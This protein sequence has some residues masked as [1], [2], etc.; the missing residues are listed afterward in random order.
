MARTITQIQDEIISTRET[1]LPTLNS[2]SRVAVWRLWTYVIAV[3]I[4]AVEKL[5]D[6]HKAEVNDIIARQKPHSLAWYREKAKAFQY[7]NDLPDGSDTY[8]IIREEDRIVKYAAAIERT[9]TVRL[10]VAKIGEPAEPGGEEDL[11][12]LSGAEMDNFEPYMHRVKDAGV[13]LIIN[14][15]TADL[16]RLTATIYYD[17]LVLA[18]DGSRLDGTSATPVTDGIRAYLKGI[19]F[20]NGLMVVNR[21]RNAIEAVEGVRIGHLTL[22]ETKYAEF[23]YTEVEVEYLPD[24]GY[25]RLDTTTLTYIPHE[26]F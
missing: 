8:S 2:E 14:S 16:L 15:A 11:A 19:D 1:Q 7:E 3:A 9:N 18:A 21:L 25:I 12:P 23:D 6:T 5:F 4:W 17:P 20:G 10:K 24:A 22:V 26:P 13:R